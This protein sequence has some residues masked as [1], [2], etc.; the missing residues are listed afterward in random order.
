MNAK[1]FITRPILACVISAFIVIGGIAGLLALPIAAYP[2][3]TP[4]QVMVRANYPG[5]NAETIAST[6]AAPLEA[7]ING[8]PNMLYMHSVSS[9]DGGLNMAIS[10]AVGSDPNLAAINVNNRVQATL[11]RL[12]E[13]VRREGVTVNKASADL[14][15]FVALDSPDDS[16]SIEELSGYALLHVLDEIRRIKGIGQADLWGRRY[17]MRIWL[18]PDKLAQLGLTTGDVVAAIRQQNSQFA[19]GRLGVEPMPL[20]V[21]FSYSV[22]A[23]GR[24]A[25]PEEFEK[26]VLRTGADGSI[27][28]LGEVARVQL[29]AQDYNTLVVSRG[30]PQVAMPMYL[31]PGANAL[32]SMTAVR[33]RMQELSKDFPP[34]IRYSVPWDTTKFI[35][36]AVQEVLLTLVEALALVF[37]VVLLFLQNWR[38][39]LIPMLAVPVSL[40][41]TFGAMYLLGSSVNMLTLFGMVLA[42]GIVVDDAIVVL[43][44]VERIMST[45]G[46]D[47][48][49]ATMKAVGEVFRPVISIV[50]VLMAVFLPVAF[51]GGLVGEM[52]RQFALTISVS[53]AISGFVALTLTPALCA[54]LLKREHVVH[55]GVLAKFNDWFTR[56]TS[57]Y[58]AGTRFVLRR[59]ALATTVFV[60]MLVACGGLYRMLPKSLVPGEDQGAVILISFLQDAA[61]LQRA[62]AAQEGVLSQ[63]RHHPAIQ[64]DASAIGMDPFTG[65]ARTNTGMTWIALKPWGERKS[66]DLSPE[67]VI[68][69]INQAA[70]N[71][72]DAFFLAVQPPPIHGVGSVGGFEVFVQAPGDRTLKELEGVTQ[73][74]IQA[75][76]QRKELAGATTTYSAS[77]PQI[78]IDLDREKAMNLGVPVNVVFETLQS[79]F[80]ALYVNDF[81]HSGRVF[82]VQLQS[83][84]RYRAYPDDIRD[85]FLRSGNGELVPLTAV[86]AV[87][88]TTGAENVDRFNAMNAAKILGAAAPGHSSGDALDAVEAV[89]RE[90]L[91]QGYSIAW[92]GSAYQERVAGGTSNS[93]YLVGVLMVFL[94]LAAQFERVTLPFAVILAVPFAAFGALLAAWGRGLDNDIYFQIGMLT[95]VGLAAKNAILIVEFAVMKQ[96]EGMGLVE[97]A[98]EGAR[99]RFRPIIMTSLALVFGV[100]PMAV[101]SGAGAA[102]RHSLGTSVIGGM[103]AATF[104]AIFFVPLFYCWIVGWTERVKA[105]F[106]RAGT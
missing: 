62:V 46:L 97:A 76:N 43:E 19:A 32:A 78:R 80:G 23:Q 12:P 101:S 41:G 98:V 106:R 2:E 42:I 45:E 79:T 73:Q 4:P 48:P 70:G 95:L 17:A 56:I 103:L 53:V 47:A 30:K 26:I 11:S 59:G 105:R 14:L 72:K 40:L 5:A 9:G 93:L 83:E 63:V 69:N 57:R 3:I 50:L 64:V 60:A 68:Q 10:F 16:R 37:L 66:A 54:L 82:Q 24:L 25:T 61:S 81:N 15:G 100:L 20:A 49:E 6:V 22:T 44:N 85:V 29:G 92:T 88:D 52:Y 67:A 65:A 34:G 51:L 13:E 33:A 74:F 102:S 89:A 87:R 38:A 71:V 7:A 91:P 1:L 104:I 77:V 90:K 8:T 31:E 94:I 96:A 35:Q 28:R 86:A 55:H 99:L 84:P 21:D 18:Q 36:E 58:E 75:L 27:V 39:T